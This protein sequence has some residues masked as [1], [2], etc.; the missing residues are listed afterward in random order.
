MISIIPMI[1]SFIIIPWLELTVGIL[2]III[3]VVHILLMI[4]AV[5]SSFKKKVGQSLRIGR[6]T[7]TTQCI[8]GGT[9]PI[10]MLLGVLFYFPGII[11][12]FPILLPLYIISGIIDIIAAI[13]YKKST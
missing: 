7:A 5:N 8:V 1:I 11:I 12:Y 6:F 2:V 10:L 3:G 9:I 13:I 4:I